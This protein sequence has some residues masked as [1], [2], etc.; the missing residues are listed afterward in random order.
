MGDEP[1]SEEGGLL[2]LST[3]GWR[4]IYVIVYDPSLVPE[5]EERT[6]SVFMD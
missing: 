3:P 1:Q 5:E 6:N 4:C 2:Q